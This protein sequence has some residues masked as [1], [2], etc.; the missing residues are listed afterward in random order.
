M[1]LSEVVTV[2]N[3]CNKV[4]NCC[5]IADTLG[6]NMPVKSGE[7]RL[8]RQGLTGKC[9]RKEGKCLYF[10]SKKFFDIEKAIQFFFH[11]ISWAVFIFFKC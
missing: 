7:G 11:F 4:F 10:T 2:L 5:L 8:K 1:H 6:D 9:K 3:K